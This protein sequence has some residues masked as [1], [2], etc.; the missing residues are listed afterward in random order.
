MLRT[1]VVVCCEL[2]DFLVQ[3]AVFLFQRPYVS[4]LREATQNQMEHAKFHSNVRINRTNCCILDRTDASIA[5]KE[6]LLADTAC[7]KH[8][9]H[10]THILLQI[11]LF[12]P[13]LGPCPLTLVLPAPEYGPL[14]C[15]PCLGRLVD[16]SRQY[17]LRLSP[18]KLSERSGS[19]MAKRG[20]SG[21][22]GEPCSPYAADLP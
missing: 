22:T 2:G 5:A 7:R 11:S 10:I 16:S 20:R 1:C 9:A 14:S 12:V 8:N 17:V 13:S 3:R 4:R 18:N 19:N 15:Q 6:Q 21:A